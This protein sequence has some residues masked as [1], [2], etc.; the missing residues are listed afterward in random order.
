MSWT[1]FESGFQNEVRDV[2]RLERRT[3]PMQLRPAL[4]RAA[5]RRDALSYAEAHIARISHGSRRSSAK[6]AAPEHKARFIQ[7]G[8]PTAGCWIN[9][10][11]RAYSLP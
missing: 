6:G 3:L 1:S 8:R 4:Q 10:D 9:N 2:R 5:F 7:A 11:R